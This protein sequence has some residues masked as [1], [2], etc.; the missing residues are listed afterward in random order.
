M[1]SEAITEEEDDDVLV[2]LIDNLKKTFFVYILT[3]S[4]AKNAGKYVKM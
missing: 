2:T 1:K 4:F 3:V